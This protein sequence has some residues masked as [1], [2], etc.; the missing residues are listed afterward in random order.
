LLFHWWDFVK[1]QASLSCGEE[2]VFVTSDDNAILIVPNL[3]RLAL[4]AVEGFAIKKGDQ[5]GKCS[6]S[7]PKK[8]A[9]KEES[10]DFVILFLI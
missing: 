4:S 2:L 3:I 9:D 5:S 8:C 7:E 10:H 1:E 6:S